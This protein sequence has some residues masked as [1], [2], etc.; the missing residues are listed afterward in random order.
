VTAEY[1]DTETR[2]A[3]ERVYLNRY[4]ELLS[5]ATSVKDILSIEEN[6]QSLQEEIESKE[7]RLKYIDGQVS[8]STM[9]IKLIEKKDIL[10]KPQPEDKF[11]ARVKTSL[12]NG[13]TSVVD[14]CLL[15][16]IK[17]PLFILGILA[18]LFV[19]RYLKKRTTKEA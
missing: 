9:R 2:L 5:K 13:W 19:R 17:W 18:L 4:K 1:I 14:F 6:V 11:S 3:N 16:I 12:S 7:R 10:I 8:Y 15:L